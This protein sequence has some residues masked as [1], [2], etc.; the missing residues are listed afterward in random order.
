MSLIYFYFAEED[1]KPSRYQTFFHGLCYFWYFPSFQVCSH[2]LETFW[3]SVKMF[4]ILDFGYVYTGAFVAF[5]HVY[6]V[7]F[8]LVFM[9]WRRLTDF[10]ILVHV[11]LGKQFLFNSSLKYMNHLNNLNLMSRLKLKTFFKLTGGQKKNHYEMND[12]IKKVFSIAK[13]V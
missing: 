6:S 1:V 8:R 12:T 7:S 11:Y 13:N 9:L 5:R 4:S 10:I 2:L 3:W